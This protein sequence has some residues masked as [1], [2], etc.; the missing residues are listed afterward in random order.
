MPK[1]LILPSE[2]MR[3]KRP[4]CHGAGALT[5]P[6]TT[7]TSPRATFRLWA[8]GEA[9]S[10]TEVSSGE[11]RQAVSVTLETSYD[12]WCLAQMASYLGKSEAS[13]FAKR[14]L[15]YANLF[16]PA[17]GFMAPRAEN[18]A[19][20]ADFDPK[21]GGGQ[22]ARDYFT[23]VNA[24]TYSFHV[25]HDPAG[26]IKLMGGRARFNARLDSL[27]QEQ[28]GSSKYFFLAQFPDATGLIGQYAQ[29][30]EPSFHIPYLYDY[31]GQPWKTQRRVRQIME[32]WY[33][34]G[35]LGLSGD[36]ETEGRFPHGMC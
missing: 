29:G 33:G 5:R 8:K 2:K 31:S 13:A 7:S 25:Q 26:L 11:K 32:L 35:P 28:Y 4:C 34:D 21:L 27:F 36:D 15:N 22:G 6:L 17:I 18:G 16:D 30:N 23:E 1:R 20:V 14:S 12:D 19:W 24:W 9:E 10:V 3:W